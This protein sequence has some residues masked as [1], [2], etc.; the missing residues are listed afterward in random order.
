MYFNTFVI[1]F[2]GSDIMGDGKRQIGIRLP[3][4]LDERLG[5]HVKKIGITKPAFILGLI[6]N[7]LEWQSRFQRERILEDSN[8]KIKE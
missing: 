2:K 4:E 5:K 6:F 3:K 7:E 8:N 1:S